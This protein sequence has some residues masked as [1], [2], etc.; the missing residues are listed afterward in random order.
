MPDMGIRCD[1]ASTV[2]VDGLL[3]TWQALPSLGEAQLAELDRNLVPREAARL[4][5]AWLAVTAFSR[6]QAAV[7]EPL[8]QTLA[9]SGIDHALLKGSATSRLLYPEPY[10]RA[11]WDLDVGVRRADLRKIEAVFHDHGFVDAQQ[12]RESGEFHRA[13]PLLKAQVEADH[14]ELGFLVRRF[15]VVNLAPEVREALQSEP[16]ARRFWF[17]TD[18]PAPRCYASVDV[19]HALSHDLAIEPLLAS[20]Q[21]FQLPSGEVSVPNAAWLLIHLIFKIYWEGAHNYGKGLYQY[22]DLV[23]LMPSID[24]DTFGYVRAVLSEHRLTAAGYYVLRRLPLF[25][26]NLPDHVT[27]FID[28]TETPYIGGDPI[29]LNDLGDMWP[30]L[31]G[32]R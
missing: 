29:Y 1:V 21:R 11:G 17:D 26:L 14:Y 9:A 23:R 6:V 13:D 4:R 30:K 32:V 15:E 25:E 19:H 5:R 31:F 16:W 27:S 8:L 3:A 10:M 2:L 22:A 7:A 12:D 20:A 28:E 24:A 18:G